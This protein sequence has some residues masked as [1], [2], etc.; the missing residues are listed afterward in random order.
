MLI[1]Q[2]LDNAAIA[3]AQAVPLV[4]NGKIFKNILSNY[5]TKQII[6]GVVETSGYEQWYE[7][8]GIDADVIENIQEAVNDIENATNA[9]DKIRAIDRAVNIQHHTGNLADFMDISQEELDTLSEIG[10]YAEI[11]DFEF[12]PETLLY[13]KRGEQKRHL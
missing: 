10:E 12:D 3:S 2:V 9:R 11:K 8:G 5:E 6:R 13:Q 1:Q 4:K 7:G